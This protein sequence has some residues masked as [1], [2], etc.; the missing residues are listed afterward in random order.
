M[1][2]I[3]Q[4]LDWCSFCYWYHRILIVM[5]LETIYLPDVHLYA[6]S[7]ISW[8]NINNHVHFV[9]LCC[10]GR[11]LLWITWSKSS[12]LNQI[13]STWWWCYYYF[14]PC[15]IIVS[16][17]FHLSFTT[18]ELQGSCSIC[19]CFVLESSFIFTYIYLYILSLYMVYTYVYLSTLYPLLHS[20][21]LQRAG[22]VLYKV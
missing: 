9:H 14:H 7:L 3:F 18:T 8:Y 17:L 13:N 15:F 22:R 20:I 19:S 16:Y 4:H 1:I 6:P 5:T 21:L 11:R 2:T 12:L 10:R